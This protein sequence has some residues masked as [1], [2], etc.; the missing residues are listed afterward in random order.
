[1]DNELF[2]LCREVYKRTGWK[3]PHDKVFVIN[4]Y[5]ESDTGIKKP[6]HYSKIGYGKKSGAITYWPLYTSDYLLE[7]LPKGIKGDYLNM[8]SAG[9][10][11]W[12]ALY[13]RTT[14]AKDTGL[15]GES[16]TPLKA[17]LKLTIVLH[18]AGELGDLGRRKGESDEEPRP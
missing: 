3:A 10:T 16:D 14:T 4:D 15:Y 6:T 5:L 18:E 12:Y 11:S 8:F 7:K 9:I 1:M 13:G 2:E 17:L